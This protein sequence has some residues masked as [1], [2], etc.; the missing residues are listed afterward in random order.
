MVLVIAMAFWDDHKECVAG[1]AI[2]CIVQ[3][4][5]RTK[6]VA[7]ARD[8]RGFGQIYCGGISDVDRLCEAPKRH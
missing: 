6:V 2:V 7:I 4:T 8:A 3:Q 1:L 5:I